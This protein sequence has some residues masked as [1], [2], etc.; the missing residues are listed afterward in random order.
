[1]RAWRDEAIQGGAAGGTAGLLRFA[2]NDDDPATI[3]D[4]TNAPSV[5]LGTPTLNYYIRGQGANGWYGWFDDAE[6]ERLCNTWLQTTSNIEQDRL[7]DAIQRVAF[8]QAPMVPLGQ[9]KEQ[10]ACRKDLTGVIPAAL[11]FPWN[12]RRS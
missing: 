7:F 8:R 2:R 1:M 9:F 10:T 11:S 5:A 6:M 4:I 3:P 12:V